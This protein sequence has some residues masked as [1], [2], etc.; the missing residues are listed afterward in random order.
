MALIGYVGYI[1]SFEITV[2]TEKLTY[3]VY[4]NS[5]IHQGTYPHKTISYHHSN[6][7]IRNGLIDV[8]IEAVY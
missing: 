3:T 7:L 1:L 8:L 4:D 6:A 2:R 5:G